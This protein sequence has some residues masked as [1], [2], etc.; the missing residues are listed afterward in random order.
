MSKIVVIDA[1]WLIGG[2]GTYTENLLLGLGQHSNGLEIRAIAREG[3]AQRVGEWCSRVTVLDVP[4]YTLKEQLF[5]PGAAKECDLLHVPHYNVPLLYRGLLIVSIMDIIHLSSPAYRHSFSSS[6]YAR[7]MLNLAAR[8]A[9][10]I[11]TVSEYSKAQIVETLGVPASKITV[12]H[13]GVSI[14][15]HREKKEVVMQAV[16]EALRINRPYLLYVGNLKPHK[17]VSTLLRAFAQLHKRNSSSHSLVIVGNDARWQRSLV[18]ECFALG[19]REQTT[20]IPHVSRA[21]LPKIY[22]GADLFV[23]PSTVEGFGLPVLEA[24]ACGTPVVC[25]KAAS[26]P[27]VGGDAAAYFDPANSEELANLIERLL[28]SKDSRE[29]LSIKGLERAKKFT[30]QEST[31]KH[32]ELYNSLIGSR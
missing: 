30:W 6:V 5:V 27:E 28:L 17:N 22:G 25:S 24:M 29:A 13:C 9:A 23:M 15:F 32:I 18:D 11:V 7:P 26:L 1:R 14:Q 10:H 4:I 12:I 19:I 3:D 21:L 8:K 31:Q 16:W 2:I 20:F